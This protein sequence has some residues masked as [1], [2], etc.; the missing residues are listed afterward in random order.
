MCQ[1]HEY[2]T[3]KEN[4]AG[5]YCGW[6]TTGSSSTHTLLRVLESRTRVS[7]DR[8][9]FAVC[10]AVAATHHTWSCTFRIS[11]PMTLTPFPCALHSQTAKAGMHW[12]LVSVVC[13]PCCHDHRIN[14]QSAPARRGSVWI[15][16]HVLTLQSLIA[17]AFVF[18]APR[19]AAVVGGMHK[20]WETTAV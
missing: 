18:V 4:D 8:I 5:G 11:P 9:P 20:R 15:R 7:Y 19:R 3:L 2:P 14:L 16:R 17:A 12:P 6:C 10:A 13:P 1:K